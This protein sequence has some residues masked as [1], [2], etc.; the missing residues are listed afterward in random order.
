MTPLAV[1]SP[2]VVTTEPLSATLFFDSASSKL[3]D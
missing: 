1:N 3:T 2:A